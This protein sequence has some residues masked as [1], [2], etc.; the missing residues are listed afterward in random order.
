MHGIAQGTRLDLAFAAGQETLSADPAG[1]PVIPVLVVL[2][3]GLPNRVP[4]PIAGGSQ[5][6]TVLAAAEAA[7]A[8]GTRVFTIA[9]GLPDDVL[10]DLLAKAASSPG[11]SFYAPD[12]E[13][14]ADIYRQIAG[15]ITA[16]P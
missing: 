3:D 16:C 1:W 12:G 6:D 10:H 4:T 11:D 5:S 9:L 7:K 2:T 8:A 14:L 13:D 15:R